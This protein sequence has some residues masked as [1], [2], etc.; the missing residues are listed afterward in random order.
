MWKGGFFEEAKAL[1]SCYRSTLEL[2]VENGIRTIAFPSIS[3]GIYGYPVEKAAKVAITAVRDFLESH[4]GTLDEVRWVLF[5]DRTMA[6]Y[7]TAIHEMPNEDR[8][9]ANSFIGS[10]Q[11]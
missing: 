10:G 4:P 8:E 3:T 1:A 6:A 7:S 11:A 2:A 9:P 5:D